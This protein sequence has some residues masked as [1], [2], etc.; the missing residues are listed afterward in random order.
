MAERYALI[1]GNGRSGTNWLLTMLDASRLTHCRNE[2]QDIATSPYHKLPEPPFIDS[3]SAAMDRRWDE[4]ATW[5]AQRMGER[6][7]PIANPKNHVHRWS[8][9]IGLARLPARPRLQRLLQPI[10]PVL[11]QGE[12]RMPAWVGNQAQLE[13]ALAILK[14]NDLKAWTAEWLFQ[15]RPQVPIIHI[16]RHPGGQLNSGIKRFF[17][18]LSPEQQISELRLHQTRLRTAVQLHPDWAAK[19]GNIDSMTLIESVAWFWRY[20]N[21]MI[22]QAGQESENY[23]A[24]VYEDLAQDPISYARKMYDFCQ[25]PW[26]DDVEHIITQGLGTSVWG[27]LDKSSKSVANTWKKTLTS[28]HQ[29]LAKQV[30]QGS[31]MQSWW[32]EDAP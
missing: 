26:T 23:L 19:F 29:E 32:A 18:N 5:T 15:Q 1:I 7:L 2:P 20:N 16:T 25:L 28:P 6:D 17:A 21:E 24:I 10:V 11:Q 4:F 3:T 22:Y 14:V 13:Q 9:K 8:Q 31:V 12:W 27:K 30:L